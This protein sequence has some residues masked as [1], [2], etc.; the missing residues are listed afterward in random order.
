ME[1]SLNLTSF[2]PQKLDIQ[3]RRAFIIS[4]GCQNGPNRALSREIKID[5]NVFIG[6]NATILPRIKIRV[7]SIFGEAAGATKNVI[8]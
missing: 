8:G 1:K 6:L 2:S 3:L 7:N 5:D 4:E